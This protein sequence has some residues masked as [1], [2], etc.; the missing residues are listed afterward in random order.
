MIISDRDEYYRDR[1]YDRYRDYRDYDRDHDD[2]Y[3]R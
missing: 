1:R 3:S 2:Y